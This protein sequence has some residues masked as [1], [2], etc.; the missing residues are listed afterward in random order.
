MATGTISDAVIYNQQMVGGFYERLAQN[1]EAFNGASNGAIVLRTEFTKGDYDQ[2]SF[3]KN[4]SALSRRV[5][6]S[7]SSASATAIT[8]DEDVAVKRKVKFLAEA[9]RDMMRSQGLDYET[10]AV[11]AGNQMA[12][13]FRQTIVNQSVAAAV[14]ALSGVSDWSL[15]VSGNGSNNRASVNNL[16]RVLAKM[17]DASN[18]VR[19]WAMSGAAFHAL[20]GDALA[21]MAFNDSGVSIYQGGVPTLGRPVLVT[22]APALTTDTSK[23]TILGLVDGAVD[24][25]NSE[26]P[27]A[28]VDDVTGN[29]NIITRYQGEAAYNLKV[30]GFKWDTN[31]GGRNPTDAAVATSTNWVKNVQSNKLLAGVRLVVQQ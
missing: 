18:N 11:L 12:D 25:N 19:M 14:A 17:G 9:T 29:E 10:A 4:F 20:I 2:K 31:A 6:T 3:F 1:I 30:K 22:D 26:A 16:N 28:V 15:D 24:V 21:T 8:M 23:Y 7:T 13:E 27:D 5:D